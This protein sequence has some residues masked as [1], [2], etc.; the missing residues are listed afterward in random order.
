MRL[1]TQIGV[2]VLSMSLAGC[3]IGTPYKS[4]VIKNTEV[5]E[6]VLISV[7]HAELKKDRHARKQFWDGVWRV[8]STMAK[9]PGY[10]GSILKRSLLGN[11]VWTM[12][13][14]TDES[15][16][17][18]FV[19]DP[20]HYQ[21]MSDNRQVLASMR[22]ARF[23]VSSDSLPVSWEQAESELKREYE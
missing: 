22:T 12:S 5:P 17:N 19:T 9:Q 13:V 10:V 11:E 23:Y 1:T 6:R 8:D 16:L 2:L 4:G 14:W 15:S 18:T 3:V 21:A 7:T 20:A